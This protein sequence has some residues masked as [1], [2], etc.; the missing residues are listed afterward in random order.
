MQRHVARF[1][2]LRYGL[3]VDCVAATVAVALALRSYVLAAAQLLLVAVLATGWLCGLR[4]ALLAWALATAAFIYY[5]TPPFDSPMMHAA[6]LPRVAIFSVL[7]ALLAAVGAARRTAEDALTRARDAL[8]TRVR[9]RTEELEQSNQRMQDAAAH[10]VAAQHRHLDLVNSAD[11][12][13]WEADAATLRFS[14][15]S[16]QA[17]R[18]L[19]YPVDRWLAEPAFWKDHLHPDDRAWMVVSLKAATAGEGP[20]P[21]EEYR[22]IAA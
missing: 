10:A 18:I 17:E 12:I 14:F 22:M 3:A 19:G 20:D 2:V 21:D 1:A 4:P 16:S 6:E 5:F 8:E 13:V 7:A 15:V 11:G 9:E